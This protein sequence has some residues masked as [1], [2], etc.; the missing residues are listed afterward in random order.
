MEKDKSVRIQRVERELHHLVARY[1]QHEIPESMPT[2]AS[3]T[4]VD[5]TSDLRKAAVYFRLVGA[6]DD[7][8]VSEKILDGHR[9]AIQSAVARELLLKFCP[10]LEFRYGKAR[11][12]DDVDRLLA[13]LHARKNNWD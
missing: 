12:E 10:V 13:G 2:L 5:V 7:A 11:E 9:K 3:V 6:P 8:K 1:V 4:A